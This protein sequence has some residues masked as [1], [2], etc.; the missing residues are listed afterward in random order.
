[1][2]LAQFLKRINMNY[3]KLFFIAVAFFPLCSFANMIKN[4]GFDE[5]TDSGKLSDW[6]CTIIG[7]EPDTVAADKND[8][9]AGEAALRISQQ[10]KNTF[11]QVTQ[12]IPVQKNKKYVVSGFVKVSGIEAKGVGPR[13][14]IT[15]GNSTKELVHFDIKN[16]NWERFR[17]VFDSKDFDSILFRCYLHLAQ[18][19]VWFDSLSMDEEGATVAVQTQATA[20]PP[21]K[22]VSH[23]TGNILINSGFETIDDNN[24]PQT[25]EYLYD[26]PD[27]NAVTID[28]TIKYVGNNSL[29]IS[30]KSQESFSRAFQSINVKP[31]TWYTISFWAKTT[32]INAKGA[33]ARVIINDINSKTTLASIPILSEEWKKFSLAFNTKEYD[34]L[35]IIYYL[36]LASGTVW[37]DEIKLEEADKT[38]VDNIVQN[39]DFEDGSA[40]IIEAWAVSAKGLTVGLSEKQKSNGARSLCISGKGSAIITSAP[41]LFD[42][43]ENFDTCRLSFD[44]LPVSFSGKEEVAVILK[45]YDA[46]GKVLPVKQLKLN[47]EKS[48]GFKKFEH[49][50][51]ISTLAAESYIEIQAA[52]PSTA[53]LFIDN[54]FLKKETEGKTGYQWQA[55]WIRPEGK[56]HVTGNIY[57]RK[58]FTIEEKAKEAWL[59]LTADDMVLNVYVN[60][61][62][63]PRGK[64]FTEVFLVDKYELSKYLVTGKNVLAVEIYNKADFGGLLCD[65]A[66][67]F[68]S[69]KNMLIK[70]DKTFKS[71]T[72]SSPGWEKL[73]FNDDSWSGQHSYGTPPA[74]L[75]WGHIAHPDLSTNKPQVEIVE[76]H[77]P[78][79]IETGKE[80]GFTIKFKP[81]TSM[82]EFSVKITTEN[83]SFT[84]LKKCLIDL[85][86]KGVNSFSGTINVPDFISKMGNCRL[87]IETQKFGL[88][89]S[90]NISIEEGKFIKPVTL[91]SNSK[92]SGLAE[93]HVTIKAGSIPTLS[94]N[95]QQAATLHHITG[96]KHTFNEEKLGNCRDNN[97]HLYWAQITGKWGY[98]DEGKYDFSKIDDFC[99]KLLSVDPNAFFVLQVNI[100]SIRQMLDWNKKYP[101]ELVRDHT[102]NQFIFDQANL[103]TPSFASK[104]WLTD[105]QAN[106]KAIVDHVSRAPYAGRVIGFTA[107]AG[108]GFEWTQYNWY[109]GNCFLDYSPPFLKGFQAWLEKKYH[110]ID[111]LNKICTKNYK[112]FSEIALPTKEERL[113]GATYFLFIEPQ[114]NQL[115][116]DYR[117]YFSENTA[118]AILT[119]AKEIKT[120]SDHKSIFGTYYGYIMYP[121]MRMTES[122]HFALGKLLDSPD[123]DFITSIL[124]YSDRLPGEFGGFMTPVDSYRLHGKYSVVQLDLRTQLTPKGSAEAAFGRCNNV[125]ESMNTIKRDFS[126]CLVSGAAF[127]IG[128]FGEG[129]ETKDQRIMALLGKCNQI[130]KDM[131]NINRKTMDPDTSIAV[132]VDDISTYYT[133]NDGGP[134]WMINWMMCY[135]QTRDLYH[136]GTGFDTFL[137]SDLGIMPDY[138][139]YIFLN[140]FHITSE[141]KKIIDEKLKKDN[142]TIV[143]L[144]APGIINETKLDAGM[145]ESVTGI[146]MTVMEKMIQPVIEISDNKETITS[147]M[148]EG[149]SY[150][151]KGKGLGPVFIPQEGKVLGTLKGK[152][153]AALVMKKFKDWT[154]VYSF[155]PN[156]PAPLIRGI[157]KYAGVHVANY[158]DSDNTYLSDRLLAVHTSTGGNRKLYVPS[159]YKN[160]AKELYT[161]TEYPILNGTIEINTAPSSTYLFLFE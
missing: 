141:Q 11:S 60:G 82:F 67:T 144:Y 12:T 143:W 111:Q 101:E 98:I 71:T 44:Y 26:G 154:S 37:L 118:D 51:A 97:I 128:Y 156:I 129:W 89:G 64:N 17:F 150:M 16:T 6:T 161:D 105:Q 68:E 155:A 113:T 30:Q 8:K 21:E 95:N 43:I 119:L 18:G 145:V 124:S 2:Q 79:K 45:S 108:Q 127:E 103:T 116:I 1:M 94:I 102:G 90:R 3:L 77:F 115:L 62:L 153:N 80:T 85:D 13:I 142:K 4:G 100:D 84:L 86:V 148:K 9:I 104:R 96:E 23:S 55:E 160:K 33:G 146:K 28:K 157:A 73:A 66:I 59:F 61:I 87:E 81:D 40:E 132:I 32:N 138:K 7:A 5:F 24:K 139:C 10:E 38:K 117:Q 56:D 49:K 63:L 114:K 126:N 158:D 74:A 39:G 54:I 123:I 83:Y 106:L 152:G 122:G 137:L 19:T 107:E 78:D 149:A 72:V 136:S 120:A 99:L 133:P 76:A 35:K 25:W 151:Y 131:Q 88:Y 130:E 147:F 52:F 20:I 140:T 27:K 135:D 109:R 42:L 112:T 15:N 121:I 36:H 47:L 159:K 125:K 58:T 41:I 46:F 48:S 92:N 65:C 93:T 75:P 57:Y 70:S 69:G 31:N 50:I 22:N 53:K 134:N 29:C 14:F 91:I 110:N 34:K